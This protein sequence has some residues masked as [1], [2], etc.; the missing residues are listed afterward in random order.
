MGTGVRLPADNNKMLIHTNNSGH[1]PP[2]SI[3]V[4]CKPMQG[5]REHHQINQHCCGD[6]NWG[7]S[8]QN[9]LPRGSGSL[10]DFPRL[11]LPLV[12]ISALHALCPNLI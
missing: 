7:L 8:L 9:I 3:V 2:R 4:L 12:H 6:G 5:D 11:G 1:K 10:G